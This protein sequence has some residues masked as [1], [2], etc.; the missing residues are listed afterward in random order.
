MLLVSLISASR[1]TAT[2]L[3]ATVLP[4]IRSVCRCQAPCT[5]NEGYGDGARGWSDIGDVLS[6][7]EED[8]KTG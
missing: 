6:V 1:Q 5:E 8:G 4:T 3:P 7:G 2:A